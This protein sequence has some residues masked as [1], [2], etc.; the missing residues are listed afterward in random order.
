MPRIKA[1]QWEYNKPIQQA[2][3]ILIGWCEIIILA[4]GLPCLTDPQPS[5]STVLLGARSL[6][7]VSVMSRQR[8]E[9]KKSTSIPDGKPTLPSFISCQRKPGLCL[10]APHEYATTLAWALSSEKWAGEVL[11][12]PRRFNGTLPEVWTSVIKMQIEGKA[13]ETPS[14]DPY[15]PL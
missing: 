7:I 11:R 14:P 13:G 6:F 1:L 10:L 15:K 5:L 2:L 12:V 9:T 3:H 4:Q 8:S